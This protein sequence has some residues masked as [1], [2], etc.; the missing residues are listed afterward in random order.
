MAQESSIVRILIASDI[1]AGFGENKPYIANDSFNTLEEVL[2][3][4]VEKN[5]D[6]VLMGIFLFLKLLEADNY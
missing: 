2:K 6:F 4:G 3:K 5:V 1:H